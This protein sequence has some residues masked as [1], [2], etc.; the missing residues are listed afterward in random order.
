VCETQEQWAARIA[1]Y[2]MAKGVTGSF[3]Y[4]YIA[5]SRNH[6]QPKMD[7]LDGALAVLCGVVTIF[8]AVRVLFGALF[9]SDIWYWGIF[10]PFYFILLKFRI[11]N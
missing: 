8:S 11:S 1:Y 7:A 4:F 2:C 6:K 5:W 9:I 10:L 3:I